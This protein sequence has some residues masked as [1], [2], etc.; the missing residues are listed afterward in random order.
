MHVQMKCSG[1]AC[2]CTEIEGVTQHYGKES[3]A[4]ARHI[5]GGVYAVAV[6][7]VMAVAALLVVL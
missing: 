5:R 7:V 3:A 1:Q 6:T 4:E 2:G